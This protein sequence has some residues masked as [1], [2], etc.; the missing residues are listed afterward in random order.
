M[1]SLNQTGIRALIDQLTT[2]DSADERKSLLENT[3]DLSQR[4]L[5]T[6]IA[7]QAT[8]TARQDMPRAERLAKLA[9]WLGDISGDKL[10]QGRS[11]RAMGNVLLQSGQHPAASREYSRA[12]ELFEQIGDELESGRTLMTSIQALIYQGQYTDA[13]AR[14]ER[15]RAIF[16]RAGDAVRMARLD[17]A[18][19]NILHRQDRFDDALLMYHR[20]ERQLEALE[21]HRERAVALL[22]MAVC[23]ISAHDYIAAERSYRDAR[24]LSLQHDMPLLTAQA[25]YNIAYLYYYRGEYTRALE[26]YQATAEF[27][28]RAG[29]V[30]HAA[31]CDLDRSEMYL[32]LRFAS[33]AA[34]LAQSA[35]AGF[36]AL[37]L[38]YE[39][40]KAM[41]FL[42]LAA[43]QEGQ[44][45]L[46]LAYFSQSGE[47]YKQEQNRPW[48]AILALYSAIVL[49]REGRYFEA[50]RSCLEAYEFLS[51]ST[52]RSKSALAGILRALLD[53]RLRENL[54]ARFHCEAAL[55]RFE[56]STPPGLEALAQY[57][58]ALSEESEGRFSEASESLRKALAALQKSSVGRSSDELKIPLIDCD[59]EIPEAFVAMN[60]EMDTSGE[61]AEE[62]FAVMERAKLRESA[63]LMAFRAQ[64]LPAPPQARSSL[65]EHLRTLR[66]ELNWYY[67]Q[68]DTQE[69]LGADVSEE[70]AAR[71]RDEIS[72]RESEYS[73]SLREWSPADADFLSLQSG[74]PERIAAIRAAL[75]T[76]ATLVQYFR[77]RGAF[78]AV[79]VDRETAHAVPLCGVGRAQDLL[80]DLRQEF[81]RC[82]SEESPAQL[83]RQT[84]GAQEIL[85][86][87]YCELFEPL[88][89]FCAHRRLIVAPHSFLSSVPFHAF[90]DGNQFLAD[91]HAISY[92]LSGSIYAWSSG[93]N[94][95]ASRREFTISDAENSRSGPGVNSFGNDGLNFEIFD[96]RIEGAGQELADG[97]GLA[98]WRADAEF[99]RDNPLFSELRIGQ[100]KVRALDV[101]HWRLP[102]QLLWVDGCEPGIDPSGDSHEL[103]ALLRGLF[104]AG[105]ET[106][107]TGLWKTQ[108][109]TTA[110]A[111]AMFRDVSKSAADRDRVALLRQTQQLLRNEC[112]HPFYWAPLSLWGKTE[113]L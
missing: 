12:L 47:R 39:A 108:D 64:S 46:A 110:R 34:K 70:H 52:L 44:P 53:M 55:R 17:I 14:A 62:L 75:P 11:A 22:N 8:Q 84:A 112:N 74:E 98:Y 65:V 72:K 26:L 109:A 13:F 101:Y 27:C 51:H 33:E 29:D 19:G 106:V 5:V 90:F 96:P 61:L 87:L 93:R 67:R 66:Q 97:C 42:G 7:D 100:S 92:T 94:Y 95:P 54:T 111:A 45:F 81:A 78:H 38:N 40:A 91:K 6:T 35:A 83:S 20:A 18:L 107:V 48:P 25:D 71:L 24:E 86:S 113:S 15:A 63:Q 21:E 36:D 82:R 30:H 79:V 4:E 99:R 60:M 41:F 80:H 23:S 32:D 37:G 16:R 3:P 58:L 59:K 105:V 102:I 104:Y 1:S 57:A 31:L 76:D 88:E 77:A 69:M 28:N 103:T 2:V 10:S 56:R 49:Y 85:K 9:C 43:Y 50:R 89:K 73:S 68:T